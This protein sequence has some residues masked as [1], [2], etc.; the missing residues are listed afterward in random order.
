MLMKIQFFFYKKIFFSSLQMFLSDIFV[1]ICFINGNNFFLDN[2]KLV[3]DFCL[4]GVLQMYVME[5]NRVVM[6]F[7][8]IVR[9][10]L[11]DVKVIVDI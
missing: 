5:S 9:D 4:S 7:L 8:I 2:I 3:F 1:K 11:G 6:W 10:N